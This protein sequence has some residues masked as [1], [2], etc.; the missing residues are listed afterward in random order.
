MT[1]KCFSAFDKQVDVLL[2][3]LLRKYTVYN[4]Q[5]ERNVAEHKANSVSW[6]GYQ[7]KQYIE[8][9]NKSIRRDVD[10][11]IS[12]IE[13][14]MAETNRKLNSKQLNIMEEKLAGKIRSIV[15]DYKKSYTNAMGGINR[16]NETLL[17]LTPGNVINEVHCSFS[18]FHFKSKFTRDK[19]LLWSIIGN[20]ISAISVLVSIILNYI[21]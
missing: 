17:E 18:F 12:N 14:L 6:G 2:N 10:E 3:R 20:I 1:N 19:A 11:L 15:A 8:D 4:L 5:F 21:G 16:T 7:E 13:I 9:F